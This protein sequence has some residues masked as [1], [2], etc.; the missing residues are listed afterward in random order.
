MGRAASTVV[1]AAPLHNRRLASPRRV[2]KL[3]AVS[4]VN[5]ENPQKPTASQNR[6]CVC[7]SKQAAFRRLL[8]RQST[9]V[10]NSRTPTGRSLVRWCC[11]VH[12]ANGGSVRTLVDEVHP[13]EILA[14]QHAAHVLHRMIDD[15]VAPE[16]P[17]HRHLLLTPTRAHHVTP[18]TH[19]R[20]P[21]L[22]TSARDI[23]SS[24]RPG[25]VTVQRTPLRGP[26][27]TNAPQRPRV[28]LARGV[29]LPKSK[30]PAGCVA[31]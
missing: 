22:R 25:R 2:K 28:I 23:I 17:Q 31:S 16:L 12:S 30:T 6:L 3:M 1:A 27:D 7:S 19:R 14:L 11:V 29:W 13:R 8:A 15:A 20:P 4:P 21:C 24:S 26:R 5:S 18:V 10:P 9:D